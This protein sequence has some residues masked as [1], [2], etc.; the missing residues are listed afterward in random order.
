MLDTSVILPSTFTAKYC[1]SFLAGSKS[2]NRAYAWAEQDHGAEQGHLRQARTHFSLN[3]AIVQVYLIET[4]YSSQSSGIE[5]RRVTKVALGLIIF[6]SL[7]ACGTTFELPE[8]G[9]MQT[10]QAT[11]M[12]AQA[13]AEQPRPDLP[14]AMAEARFQRVAPRV[15]A[16]GKRYCQMVTESREAFNCDVNVGIDRKMDS[17]NAYFTH[18]R[19]N[20]PIIRITIPM[21]KDTVSDDE[22]AFILSHEYGHLIGRHIEKQ[23]QQ[24]LAGALILGSIAAAANSYSV[25]NGGY[26]NP[27]L[28]NDSMHAGAMIG[29]RAYS[30]AYELESDTLGTRIA[31][32]AGYDP[33]K[34][35]KFFA[36]PE[37]ARSQTGNLSF[38]GTHP[39]DEKRFATVLATM[40]EIDAKI[41]LKLTKKSSD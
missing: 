28:V 7:T 40:A 21:L 30:Q 36:R 14:Q 31:S 41:G 16:T 25:A 24:E 27:N 5:M 20:N 29:A 37:K 2:K 9:E 12:F 33:I 3:A 1:V 11:K 26:N 23:K 39:P 35:A 17:R 19:N 15:V 34:G 10:Q 13:R 18:D 32:S 6:G 22:V 4:I 8:L 38:W